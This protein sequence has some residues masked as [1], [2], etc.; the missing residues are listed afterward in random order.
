MLRMTCCHN[1]S[2]KNHNS[3][4]CLLA[5]AMCLYVKHTIC[6]HLKCGHALATIWTKPFIGAMKRAHLLSI[7]VLVT[8]FSLIS[9]IIYVN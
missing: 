9:I 7:F 6:P 2:G 3:N 1:N 5:M 8:V 4:L